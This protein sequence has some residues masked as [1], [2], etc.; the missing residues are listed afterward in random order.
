MRFQKDLRLLFQK[1]AECGK[2]FQ[3]EIV[4]FT[5]KIPFLKRLWY[6]W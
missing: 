5:K 2:Y 1:S 6:E 3:K 4:H